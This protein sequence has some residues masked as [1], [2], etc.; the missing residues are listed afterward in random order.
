VEGALPYMSYNNII[1][2]CSPKV[3]GF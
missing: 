1:D 2:M 3:Y